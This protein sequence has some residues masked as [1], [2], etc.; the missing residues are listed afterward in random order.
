MEKTTV[1]VSLCTRTA[2]VSTQVRQL[3]IRLQETGLSWNEQ[4]LLKGAQ[5]QKEKYEKAQERFLAGAFGK[6]NYCQGT[7]NSDRLEVMPDAELCINCQRQLEKQ[8]PFRAQT[9]LIA[10]HLA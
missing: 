6:C 1:Y 7:I 5:V 10:S 4:N 9:R 3:E 2:Q 8:A